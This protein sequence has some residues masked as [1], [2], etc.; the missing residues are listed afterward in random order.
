VVALFTGL[1]ADL[2]TVAEVRATSDGV[3]LAI[4]SRW[5]ASLREGDS[6]AVNGVCLTAVGLRADRFGADVMHETLRRSSL[7]EALDGQPRQPRASR[8][9]A[10]IA[11]AATSSRATSTA[12]RRRCRRRDDG[13]RA[14][15][16]V[17]AAPARAALRRREGLDRRRTAYR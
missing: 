10:R 13:F 6:V 17:E 9:R 15:R 7:G 12:R 1:V 8:S 11:S 14:R 3:R 16:H 4:A 5:R 2:G